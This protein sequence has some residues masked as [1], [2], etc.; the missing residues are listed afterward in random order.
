MNVK[1]IVDGRVRSWLLC[2][3]ILAVSVESGKV[4]MAQGDDVK[5]KELTESAYVFTNKY[6]EA[7]VRLMVGD[8][9][10]N[11]RARQMYP[12]PAVYDVDSD[13]KVELVVGDIFGSLNVYENQNTGKGD[14]VWSKHTR[15]K[16]AKGKPI[17][18]SN[19]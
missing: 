8:Q 7:P 16:T 15:L 11:T 4:A 2:A 14:P 5:R 17:K 9:P 12:S 10:L 3:C 6:F 19:W 1:R 13:G 18:V